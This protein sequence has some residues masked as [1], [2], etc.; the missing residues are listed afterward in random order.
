MLHRRRR[1]AKLGA[2][3]FLLVLS[4]W[5]HGQLPE[6]PS[7]SG[8]RHD[9]AGNDACRGCHQEIFSTYMQSAHHLA[10]RP[11]NRDSIH[12]KFTPGGNL[13]RT[14]NPNVYFQMK[15]EGDAFFQAAMARF[16][17]SEVLTRQ[18]P[19]DLVIG[20]GR[21]GQTYLYWK[22]SRL[23]ELPVSL[24]SETGEWMNSP[25]YIDGLPNFDRAIIPRCMEC[26]AT[27]IESRGLPNVYDKASLLTGIG[28]EKCHGPGR[29]HA[30]S[31]T[32]SNIV[33]PAKL[34]RAR[35]IDLCALCH[36]GVGEAKGASFA[37]LP[38]DDL[39]KFV[40]L[41]KDPP[42]TPVDVHAHQVQLLENSRCFRSSQMT[43]TTCHDV[44][45]EQRDLSYF[46]A[47]CVT[48]HQAQQCGKFATLGTD[49]L[50]KC[51]DCHMPLRQTKVIALD[52]GGHSVNPQVRTHRIAV[53][54]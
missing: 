3:L 18:E 5:L 46:S 35:Q 49:I 47:K 38:G 1:N 4:P 9:Y 28:C 45:T 16:P 30:Q 54:P 50:H 42:D 8:P 21:K 17:P 24:W 31:P 52:A 15:A 53:Y 6:A 10:S 11:A 7:P 2:L 12:G 37:F 48:C 13:L 43:C 40:T 25:G 51:V 29:A 23:F 33:N 34:S 27:F 26:H 44:H 22:G 32:A 14:A 20:S 36:A 39:A 41:P 19:F